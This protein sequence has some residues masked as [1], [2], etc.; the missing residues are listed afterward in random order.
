MKTASL[1]RRSTKLFPRITRKNSW[2]YFSKRFTVLSLIFALASAIA[3]AGNPILPSPCDEL[4]NQGFNNLFNMHYQE[5]K[6]DFEGM[7]HADPNQPAGYIYLG[8]AIWLN[9]LADLRRLQTNVYN[10][11]NAFFDTRTEDKADAKVDA[12]FRKNMNKGVEL[13]EARLKKD[14]N[15]LQAMYYLGVAKNFLAGYEATV[16]RSFFSALR[17]GSKGVDLHRDVIE[18]DPKFIDAYLSVGMYDYIVGSLPLAVKILVF[19]GGVHGSKKDGLAAVEKVYREGVYGKDEAGV[20]LVMLYDREKRRVDSLNVLH[21]LTKKFPENYLFALERAMAQANLKRFEESYK[22]FDSILLNN[23]AMTRMPD[24]I[25][26]QY[27]EALFAGKQWNAALNHYV[28]ATKFPK[29]PQS[30]KTMAMLSEGR[31]Y[32]A[33]GQ[34]ENALKRY[35]DVLK[36]DEIFNSHDIAK[37]FQKKP[38]MPAP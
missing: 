37:S 34:R 17:N 8:Y 10:K 3:F 36:R 38:F 25:H 21:D 30:L 24:I 27:A 28:E 35:A 31:C 4:R 18:K 13:A 14:K 32:D 33:M 23:N 22:T 7:I 29:A 12:E 16:N 19:F 2:N 20:L 15:D 9:Y 26:Y 1:K 5:S 11:N 6:T